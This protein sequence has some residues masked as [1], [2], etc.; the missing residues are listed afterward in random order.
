M[1]KDRILAYVVDKCRTQQPEEGVTTQEIADA[2]SIWRNDVAVELNK[3]VAEGKLRREGKKNIRFFPADGQARDQPPPSAPETGPT[4]FSKLVG[5]NGSLKHQISVS[6]AAAAYPSHGLNMLILG[7]TGSGKSSFAK[8]VWEYAREINAFGSKDGNIPFVVF[9]CAEYSDNPQL[10]LSHLF[11]YKKGAFTGALEDKVG[12]VEEADGGILLLDEIHHLSAAGQ[13]LFFTLLDTGLYHRLGDVTTRRSQFMLIGATTKPVTDLLDTFLRRMPVLI[14]MPAL[15]ERPISE[16]LEF[17]EHFYTEEA[18]RIGRPLRIQR[19]VLNALL[20]YTLYA[21]LGSLKNTI[22]ISCAKGYLRQGLSGGDREVSIAFSDLSFQVHGNESGQGVD[23]EALACFEGDMH[24]SGSGPKLAGGD[25]PEFMDIYD[26]VDNH[27]EQGLKKGLSAEELQQIMVA[28]VDNYYVNMDRVLQ[29]PGTDVSL[30]NSVL[31]PGCVGIS[32]EFLDR[33]SRE[34]NRVYPSTAP[35]LLAMHISQYVDR[36]RSEQPSFPPNLLDGMKGY[37]REAAFLQKN[38]EWLSSALKV[39]ITD[40]EESFLAIFLSQVANRSEAPRVWLTV[41]SSNERTASSMTKFVSSVCHA[42]HL[43]WVDNQSAG[44]M[45]GMFNSVCKNIRTFHGDG[46]NLIFTDMKVLVGLECELCR[47][48][49]VPCKVIPILEQHILM[50]ACRTTMAMW[51]D[52]ETTYQRVL[53]NYSDFMYRFFRSTSTQL[54]S[55]PQEEDEEERTRVVL[56]ICV[57]G[58]GSARSIKEILEKKLSYIPNLRI[59]ALSTLEDFEAIYKTY[60]KSIK[61]VVGTVDPGISGVP[62]LSADRVFTA[63]GMEYISSILDN[64]GS[65]CFASEEGEEPSAGGALG[66][67]KEN[68]DFIAPNVDRDK[69]VIC[70]ERMISIL[71]SR[72]Y[73]KPIPQDVQVRLFMHAASMLERIVSGERLEEDPEHERLIRQ[74]AS[75]Y[76]FLEHT[77]KEAFLPYGCEI[78]P[79]EYFYFMLS[80][81]ESI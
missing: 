48:T 33:A 50:D 77:I 14:Q 60:D 59:V 23:P 78:P 3:L 8:A 81:P 27:L 47:A 74:K 79:V 43:H 57:T 11:G 24:I 63:S 35:V 18:A 44:A 34:L 65:G 49:G 64:W 29:E 31:F 73:K 9:N 30:L 53:Q 37:V 39:K 70:I 4:A 25:V 62:F 71:E 32:A 22:Q 56:S 80:L 10:L 51:D 2:L 68:F 40:D 6:K 17:I 46:G 75:W 28:E 58:I 55:A 19:E 12:L 41:V 54:P 5:A 52:L 16:R 15:F 36:M 42:S 13:E 45:N 1:R 72:Y 38:R 76:Q 69:A 7:P 26:F 66:L 21:N 61:L 67:L 20:G